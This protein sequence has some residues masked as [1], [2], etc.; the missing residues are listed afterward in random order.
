[1][2]VSII[3]V[4]YN[5]SALIKN[6][7]DSLYDKTEGVNFEVIVVDNNPTEQFAVD[8]E[9]YIDKII[10][11]P[12]NENVGF[13][14]ANNEGLKVAKGRNIFFLNPDTLL[15]N[16]AIKILS[17]YLD[18][19]DKVGVCGGNL[20]DASMNPTHSYQMTLPSVTWELNLF[21]GK[22]MWYKLV[23][24]KNYTH[25]YTQK[26]KEVAYIT[27]ADM[28][29]KRQV[30]DSVGG[31][32]PAFFMYYEETELSYRIQK[33]GYKIMSVP[34]A[35]I[36]HLEGKS[37]QTNLSKQQM[38]LASRKTYYRLTVGKRRI[39]DAICKYTFWTRA[40]MCA[41][42]GKQDEKIY[43]KNSIKLI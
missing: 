27:G 6:L 3:I 5:T 18:S 34:D 40:M 1:M 23:Y 26:P 12:L 28:M 30:L 17:D 20:Y 43:W 37:I 2:D 10:Y 38:L 24:G 4:N 29:V 11:I 41:I 14:R 8:L 9:Y 13:G 32:N 7:L 16:N 31:F 42:K 19:H 35:K 33:N 21:F 22:G 39:D 36:M 15:L 25:N